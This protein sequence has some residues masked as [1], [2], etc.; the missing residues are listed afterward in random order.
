MNRVGLR[1]GCRGVKET[2]VRVGGGGIHAVNSLAD[3]ALAGLGRPQ[4]AQHVGA[5]AKYEHTTPWSRTT[6]P[7]HQEHGHPVR[8]QQQGDEAAQVVRSVGLRCPGPSCWSSSRQQ[9]ARG[10]W[11]RARAWGAALAARQ[12]FATLMTWVPG[13][14]HLRR[15]FVQ[16][17]RAQGLEGAGRAGSCCRAGCSRGCRRGTAPHPEDVATWRRRLWGMVNTDRPST[18]AALGRAHKG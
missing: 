13:V 6:S 18:S 17:R 7:V 2:P 14:G 16:A 8:D 1:A 5:G 9:Q 12:A 11:T 3:L 15:G 10:C 4:R